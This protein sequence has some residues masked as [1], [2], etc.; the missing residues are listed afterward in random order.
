MV[1]TLEPCGII[2]LFTGVWY[3]KEM[4]FATI[5][6]VEEALQPFFAVTV[7]TTGAQIT[8]E[9]TERLMAHLGNPEKQL[10]IIHIA[11]TSGKTSTTYYT[12]ALLQ[13]SGKKVG[14]TVSP[15]IHS[16]TERIQLDGKPLTERAFCDYFAEFYELVETAPETPSWFEC[17]IAFTFWVFAKEQVDYAVVETGMG[18]LHDSTN[19]A[20]RADKVCVIT[21]IGFDH[22]HILGNR[23]GAIAHQKAGIIHEGNTALMYEQDAEIM[24]VVRYWVSQQ[25]DAELLTFEQARLAEAYGGEFVAGLPDYQRRNWLLAFAAYRFLANRDAL[26]IISGKMLLETQKTVV[27]GR[28]DK[29]NVGGKTIVMDGAHNEQKMRAFVESFEHLYPGKKVPVLLAI[30]QSKDIEAIAPLLARV[31]ST[32]IASKFDRGQDLPDNALSPSEIASAL[33]TASIDTIAQEADAEK[34][35]ALF[36]EQ[37]EDVGIVTGSFFLISELTQKV[38]A[39]Q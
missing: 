22:M 10:Q 26:P 28:M 31:A 25:E 5:A 21:D 11:G 39:L 8:I 6:E 13:T 17:L 2:S 24:Q 20:A 38:K 33:E 18:G 7:E 3:G 36:L 4:K 29:R 15:H 16:L 12:T 35:F 27:P 34:A 32:V 19:V 30:K 9:R 23:L 1:E 37:I 14:H